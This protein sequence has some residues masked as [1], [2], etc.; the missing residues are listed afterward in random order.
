MDGVITNTMPLHF[1]TWK[2]VLE[3]AGVKV[4]C[5]DIYARE[6]EKGIVTVKSML[7]REG[8]AFDDEKVKSILAKKEAL[9]QRKAKPVLIDHAREFIQCLKAKKFKLGL[10][11]GT[12]RNELKLILPEDIFKLFDMS[13]TGDEVTDGKPHPEPYLT[14]LEKLG[15]SAKDAVVIENAPYGIKSAK[16]AGIFTIAVET[17]LPKKYL[18]QADIILSSITAAAKLI[19]SS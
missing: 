9:F 19:C 10:V 1:D 12:S 5:Y 16:A 3:E 18:K 8:I 2:T 6:G 4:N 7:E 13:V 17:S 14:A 15:I 11:T